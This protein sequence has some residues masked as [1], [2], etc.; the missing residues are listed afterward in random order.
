MQTSTAAF[1]FSEYEFELADRT[2]EET[3][4]NMTQMLLDDLRAR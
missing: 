1:R 3:L 2:G 4:A